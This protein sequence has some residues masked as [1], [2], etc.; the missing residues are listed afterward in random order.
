M[1]SITR[2]VEQ[3]LAVGNVGV[4]VTV[5]EALLVKPSADMC[6]SSSSP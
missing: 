6:I 1:A 5:S 2:D 3:A 4:K